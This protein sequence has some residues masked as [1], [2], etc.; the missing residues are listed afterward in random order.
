MDIMAFRPFILVPVMVGAVLA[1]VMSVTERH[2]PIIACLNPSAFGFR[3]HQQV[4]NFNRPSAAPRNATRVR[5]N[6][7]QMRARPE[8]AMLGVGGHVGNPRIISNATR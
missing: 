8:P 6:V 7:R 3:P 4:M 5:G 1:E 2:G